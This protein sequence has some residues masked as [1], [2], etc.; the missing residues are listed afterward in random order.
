MIGSTLLSL[1]PRVVR[2]LLELHHLSQLCKED[3]RQ[4][5][6]MMESPHKR[7]ETI[8]SLLHW[9]HPRNKLSILAK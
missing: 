6:M 7:G 8:C 3:E 9:F 1:P 5:Q 4:K 2:S